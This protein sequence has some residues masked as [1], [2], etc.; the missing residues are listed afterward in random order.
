MTYLGS[1]AT[2]SHRA[3]HTRYG[4]IMSS[5]PV[6]ED[7][8]KAATAITTATAVVM[9]KGT[10]LGRLLEEKAAANP[11]EQE[12]VWKVLA[13][14]WVELFVYIAASSNEHYR[15]EH[16]CQGPEDLPR[17]NARALGKES[18]PRA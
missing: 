15:T 1:R 13:N 11:D 3:G 7:E 18:L 10:A 5:K 16:L 4:K 8:T 2:T 12:G 6:L 17:E 14:L 9:R